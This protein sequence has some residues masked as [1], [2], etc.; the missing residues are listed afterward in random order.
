MLINIAAQHAKNCREFV[1]LAVNFSADP[2]DL[3]MIRRI[4]GVCYARG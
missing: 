1:G 3:R 2:M 4:V